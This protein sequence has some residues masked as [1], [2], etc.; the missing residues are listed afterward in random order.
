[1]RQT[2]FAAVVL[3]VATL[4]S[5]AGAATLRGTGMSSDIRAAV[6]VAM[7]SAMLHG[8][9]TPASLLYASNVDMPDSLQ[10]N[11]NITHLIVMV[12]VDKQGVPQMAHVTRA[13]NVYI[14][15]RVCEA[16]E[17]YRFSPAVRNRQP[18]E[19]DLLLNISL[20]PA[21]REQ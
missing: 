19:S 10:M 8:G 5:S 21:D 18:V 20:Q 7:E 11:Q 14:D 17:R 16:V 9:S 6:A 15:A 13:G 2:L 12:R 4:A 1:M 3:S